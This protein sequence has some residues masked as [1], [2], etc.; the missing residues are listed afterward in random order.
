MTGRPCDVPVHGCVVGRST[1]GYPVEASASD[2]HSAATTP[3]AGAPAACSISG[4]ATIS[5]TLTRPA[6]SRQVAIGKATLAC[7]IAGAGAPLL[8]VHGLGGNRGTWDQVI[9]VLAAD[10]TVIAPDLPGH[11]GQTVSATRHLHQLADR[12]TMAQPFT[13]RTAV[14][15]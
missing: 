4:D 8:L 9:D 11:G 10:F 12:T 3:S 15:G 14:S 6:Q 1:A 5:I 7:T 13:V 2:L